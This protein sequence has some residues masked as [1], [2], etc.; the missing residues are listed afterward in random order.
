[1]GRNLY[2]AAALAGAL[3]TVG[4]ASDIHASSKDCFKA[5]APQVQNIDRSIYL[6]SASTNDIAVQGYDVTANLD[7]SRLGGD[8]VIDRDTGEVV[9]RS[10]NAGTWEVKPATA[11]LPS[12]DLLFLSCFAGLILVRRRDKKSDSR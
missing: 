1:M 9:F 8:C 3:V 11:R 12:S 6:A 2:L 4:T 10:G 5:N 7:C